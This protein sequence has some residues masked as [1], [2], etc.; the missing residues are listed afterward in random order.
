MAL[1]L[2]RLF[3]TDA[4]VEQ[5]RTA[6]SAQP[7]APVGALSQAHLQLGLALD[8]LGYRGE[9][10]EEY[11]AALATMPPGDPLKIQRGAR[12]GLRIVPDQTTAVAYRF[13]IEGWRALE[14]GAFAEAAQSLTR[15]L[16]LRPEDPVTRYRQAHLQVAVGNS[17]GALTVLEGLLPSR[18]SMPPTIYAAVC[19]ETAELYEQRGAHA[20]AL[21]LY[22][23]AR[24]VFGVDD[25]T[26]DAAQRG[27]ARLTATPQTPS[28]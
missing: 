10:V 21:D 19:L 7:S 22:R 6:V 27:V 4:A 3:E 8:R 11:R 2:D 25:R 15:S 14:R 5:L 9:A 17:A 24:G 12:A 13:S 23:T 18:S 26:R 28:R 20:R 1:Q 16:A